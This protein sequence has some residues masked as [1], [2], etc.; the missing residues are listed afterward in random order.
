M[1]LKR[2][3]RWAARKLHHFAKGSVHRR[4]RAARK[5]AFWWWRAVP[6]RFMEHL[7]QVSQRGE[8]L[9]LEEYWRSRDEA[10]AMIQAV[11]HGVWIRR[12][13]KRIR[14][15][16][17]IQRNARG[18]MGRRRALRILRAVQHET[19]T[20]YVLRLRREALLKEQN[21]I[22]RIHVRTA[23][24]IQAAVRR[25]IVVIAIKRA[26]AA[27]REQVRCASLMQNNWRSHRRVAQATDGILAQKRRLMNPYS[28]IDKPGLVLRRALEESHALYDPSNEYA[29]LG[30][31][32]CLRRLGLDDAY[33]ILSA[34]GVH[35][36]RDLRE[37]DDA[38]LETL[39]MIDGLQI[40]GQWVVRVHEAKQ[41][42]QLVVT[43][44]AAAHK[45]AEKRS[46]YEAAALRDFEVL[47]DDARRKT[48]RALFESAYSSRFASRS[49]NFAEAL[50][51]ADVTTH[52]LR[53]YLKIHG[54][55][56]KAKEHLPD[57]ASF[58]EQTAELLHDEQRV[59]TACDRL[60]FGAE[61]LRDLYFGE[62]EQPGDVHV[63]PGGHTTHGALLG[64]LTLTMQ[65]NTPKAL[66]MLK[67]R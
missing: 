7:I 49:A 66:Q 31:A 61:R 53:R 50:V 47:E 3:E 38:G 5:I 11:L 4:H 36:L 52:Q 1:A 8:E 67:D 48:A 32:T 10:A 18:F 29:G 33:P 19:A 44:C 42:R 17:R 23:T 22:R 59:V 40:K 37:H 30:L 15:V 60:R 13:I 34:A 21:R 25:R 51:G 56:A 20:V 57:L 58:D 46:S 65:S 63:I 14:A 6:G 28:G 55:P 43:F 16:E 39:G 2:R 12:Q 41:A 45:P 24:R 9:E 62:D 35:S 26:A 27:A 54:T 64:V